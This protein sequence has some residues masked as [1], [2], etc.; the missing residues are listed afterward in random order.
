MTSLTLTQA[1]DEI[2][3]FFRT[4]WIANNE[5]Q[6]IP[7]F[8]DDAHKAVPGTADSNEA[9]LPWARVTLRHGNFFQGSLSGSIG[10]RRFE[11]NGILVIQI[12]TPL[13]DGLT[14]ADKLSIIA[15]NSLEGKNTTNGVWF[16]NVRV[17][18]IGPDGNWFQTNIIA[19]FIYDEIK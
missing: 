15:L 4:A 14:T 10:Q 13:N 1:R 9:P 12:F 3:T 2:L 11:R 7:L 19:E 8:F 17:N 6:N 16:R 18:E 5:S